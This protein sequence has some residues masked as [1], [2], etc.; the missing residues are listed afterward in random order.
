MDMVMTVDGEQSNHHGT[1]EVEGCRAAAAELHARLRGIDTA[2]EGAVSLVSDGGIGGQ[3]EIL[4]IV[5]D[6]RVIHDSLPADGC[7]RRRNIE[8]EA[9]SG[10]D[11]DK[12]ARANGDTGR[13]QQRGGG[14]D[15]DLA[16]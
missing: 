5:C 4:E 8:L 2:E 14:G 15:E 13:D 12:V 16:A 10:C 7:G 6:A 3:T 9:P 11:L 1:N